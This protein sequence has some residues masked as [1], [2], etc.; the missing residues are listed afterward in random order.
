[1]ERHR[2]GLPGLAVPCGE[3]QGEA[4]LGQ[5]RGQRMAPMPLFVASCPASA[6]VQA[7]VAGAWPGVP[8]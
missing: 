6:R 1:M 2:G 7:T 8:A 5:V 3:H 4:M